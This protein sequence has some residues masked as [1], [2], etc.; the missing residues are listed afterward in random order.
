MYFPMKWST[1]AT[2]FRASAPDLLNGIDAGTQQTQEQKIIL[3]QILVPNNSVAPTRN[4]A[5]W[6]LK[7]GSSGGT[8]GDDNILTPANNLSV[9]EG[10]RAPAR[11]K[12][13]PFMD[14]FI[15]PFCPYRP[16]FSAGPLAAWGRCLGN[17]HNSL[18]VQLIAL[19][20]LISPHPSRGPLIV[21]V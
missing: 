18:S 2:P 16:I 9:G 4:R 6:K 7:A 14:T 21:A 8:G 11:G 3:W 17:C 15:A 10:F 1:P 13:S 12:E 19:Q 5:S 20:R